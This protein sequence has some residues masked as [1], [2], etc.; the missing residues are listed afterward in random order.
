ML[1]LLSIRTRI[2]ITMFKLRCICDANFYV[3]C[4][5]ELVTAKLITI[6]TCVQ[7]GLKSF[8]ISWTTELYGLKFAKLSASAGDFL[9]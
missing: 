3:I 2:V 9:T 5:G 1:P 4:D 8:I 7:V 6:L